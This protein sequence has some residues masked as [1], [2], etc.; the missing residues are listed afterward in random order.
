MSNLSRNCSVSCLI[1]QGA[2]H[3]GCA[4]GRSSYHSSV[5]RFRY[6]FQTKGQVFDTIITRSYPF[7]L[8][9]ARQYVFCIGGM[10]LSKLREKIDF[11]NLSYFCHINSGHCILPL[12]L[13]TTQQLPDNCKNI[14]P[15]LPGSQAPGM[16]EWQI[17]LSLLR[18]A[19]QV[20]IPNKRPS[21]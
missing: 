4:N 20:W 12:S 1:C 16:H 7:L 14:L 17:V 9:F 15:D 19:L 3:L 10:E 5:K 8:C 21:F 2:R 6:G 11:L 18:K 13:K